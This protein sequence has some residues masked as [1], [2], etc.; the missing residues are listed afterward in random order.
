MIN[1]YA[2]YMS[3]TLYLALLIKFGLMSLVGL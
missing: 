2:K 1:L 3:M